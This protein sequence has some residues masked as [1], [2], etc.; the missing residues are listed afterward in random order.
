MSMNISI[1]F[2]PGSAPT[3]KVIKTSLVTSLGIFTAMHFVVGIA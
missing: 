1:R 3:Q 2:H